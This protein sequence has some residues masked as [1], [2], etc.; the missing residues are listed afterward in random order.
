MDALFI[1]IIGTTACLNQGLL[2]KLLPTVPI[3][4]SIPP[5]PFPQLPEM[6]YYIYYKRVHEMSA[7]I[8]NF[9]C[10]DVEPVHDL[11]TTVNINRTSPSTSY[12]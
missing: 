10:S 2:Q 3:P 6:R 4:C 12:G 8:T 11:R 7:D 9:V 1:T 5:I